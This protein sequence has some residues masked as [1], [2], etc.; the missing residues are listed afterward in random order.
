M[1]LN[2]AIPI[3][4]QLRD[5]F[6]RRITS[7]SWPPGSK[8][9]S[10][11]DLAQTVGANPNTVQRALS[12]LEREGLAVSERTA[13][14]FVTQDQDKIWLTRQKVFLA[15]TDQYDATMKKA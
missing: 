4:S 3:W 15:H 14:R 2:S 13:G 1:E 10:V 9:P 12:E 5:E 8:I 6:S 11:R 7:G